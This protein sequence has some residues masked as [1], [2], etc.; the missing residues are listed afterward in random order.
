MKIRFFLCS[1]FIFMTFIGWNL[2]AS[3]D[4]SSLK[5]GDLVFQSSRTHQSLAIFF[6]SASPYTHV[7][8]VRKSNEKWV[9]AEASSTVKETPLA[10]WI[11]NGIGQR[12][13]IYRNVHVTQVQIKAMLRDVERFYGKKYD[14]FFSFDNDEIYCSELPYLAYKKQGISI[15]KVEKNADL[16]MNNSVVKSLIKER[17]GRYPA[18]KANGI[19]GDKCYDYILQ[20]YLITPASIAR[21]PHF[22]KIFSNYPL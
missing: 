2:A 18:C 14:I 19:A 21:D 17:M 22:K 15:G 3:P 5:E 9:V 8:I 11:R 13:A 16:Y 20:Q 10:D 1:L 12:V 7:G 6:A 4:L